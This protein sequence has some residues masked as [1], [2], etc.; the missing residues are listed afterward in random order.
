MSSL[1]RFGFEG[2]Y[3]PNGISIS[4]SYMLTTGRSG[5]SST[6]IASADSSGA[7]VVID[8]KEP[9]SEIFITEHV[10]FNTYGLGEDVNIVSFGGVKIDYSLASSTFIYKVSGSV[11]W[12]SPLISIPPSTFIP[13]G[14]H[15]K[16]GN[17]GKI[18]ATIDLYSYTYTGNTLVGTTDAH[19]TKIFLGVGSVGTNQPQLIIDDIAINNA[20]SHENSSGSY[21][22]LD[23]SY[24]KFIRGMRTLLLSTGS[25]FQW[26]AGDSYSPVNV[27]D[28]VNGVTSSYLLT[29]QYNKYAMFKTV[30]IDPTSIN[31]FEG[32][33]VFVE[34]ATVIEG[35]NNVYLNTYFQTTGGQSINQ[36]E[37]TSISTLPTTVAYT[38][39]ENDLGGHMTVDDFNSGSLTIVTR[40][41]INQNYF[42]TGELGDVAITGSHFIPANN[43]FTFV[44]YQNLIITSGSVLTTQSPCKGLVVYVRENCVIEGTIS[45]D[46]RGQR[47]YITDSPV[48][49][50]RNTSSFS[51]ESASSSPSTWM[52]EMA[53]QPYIANTSSWFGLNVLSSPE[54]T[55]IVGGGGRGGDSLIGLGGRGGSSSYWGG[56]CGGGGAGGV[57]GATT[58]NDALDY[59][60]PG[61]GLSV[62]G[63]GSIVG[64]G[65]QY[66]GGVIYLFVGG[67]LILGPQSM[68]T[69]TGSDGGST[70]GTINPVGGGGGAGGG[71]INVF[72]GT[73]LYDLGGTFNVNG[74]KGTQG[75]NGGDD[76]QDGSSGSI[77]LFHLLSN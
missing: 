38:A 35:G 36:S 8:S 24:P 40:A 73:N 58:G 4:G 16:L 2:G 33:N 25:M 71:N 13:M 28:A 15:I 57:A 75:V 77:R 7:I 43:D 51:F 5:G 27:M 47:G 72:Y 10:K 17:P 26:A 44:E 53:A 64:Q 34:G 31:S 49:V 30:P 22:T 20:I 14:F 42:G 48:N 41:F 3:L 56:G 6:A 74:G 52:S 76:G 61:G 37:N 68:I 46:G 11:V 55:G 66:G 32:V 67:N 50:W 29:H 1:Y 23:A 62:E 21:G 60:T 9:S 19:P 54:Q 39:V 65:A 70:V 45:M 63:S 59:S 18:E 12:Q 69:A